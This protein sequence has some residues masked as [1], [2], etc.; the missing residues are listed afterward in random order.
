M[1]DLPRLITNSTISVPAGGTDFGRLPEETRDA[2]RA[3]DALISAAQNTNG[4]NFVFGPA[5]SIVPNCT[6]LFGRD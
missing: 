2:S 1:I 4:R 5:S 6:D 3:A